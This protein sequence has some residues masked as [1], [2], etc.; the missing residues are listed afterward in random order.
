MLGVT[1]KDDATASRGFVRK[2]KAHL[3]EPARRPAELAPRFGTNKLPETFVLDRGGKVVAMSR[4]EVDGR[5]STR[6]IAAA[7]GTA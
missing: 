2:Y 3:P 7:Q 5:S 4:G 6:A 1:Y